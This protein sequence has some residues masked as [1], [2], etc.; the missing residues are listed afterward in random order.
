M[1]IVV[2]GTGYVGL[3]S[4]ACFADIGHDVTCVDKNPAVLERLGRGE[5]P[6]YEPGL[7]AVVARGVDAERLDFAASPNAAM[8]HAD[9]VFIAVGTPSDGQG[10][11]D[12]SYVFA[13]AREIAPE[14]ASYTVVATKSTVPVGTGRAV[15]KIIKETAP[16]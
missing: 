2:I 4:G 6:I 12:L 13:A 9:L 3:V 5:I 14:I 11:A 1:R 7:G 10:D 15:A 8:L 16:E